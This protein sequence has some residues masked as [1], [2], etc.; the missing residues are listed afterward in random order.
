MVSRGGCEI[1]RLWRSNTHVLATDVRHDGMRDRAASVGAAPRHTPMPN[2]RIIVEPKMFPQMKGTTLVGSMPLSSIFQKTDS[3]SSRRGCR[4]RAQQLNV[5][6]PSRSDRSF[7]RSDVEPPFIHTDVIRTQGPTTHDTSSLVLLVVALQRLAAS[8]RAYLFRTVLD[9]TMSAA[10][11]FIELFGKRTPQKMS[12]RCVSLNEIEPLNFHVCLAY[13]TRA[14]Q[15]SW[16]DSQHCAR[17]SIWRR[18]RPAMK[19]NFWCG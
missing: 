11:A 17:Y 3:T 18:G 10:P 19:R 15:M 4:Q 8:R 9:F 14:L 1:V 16:K 5:R 13:T 7:K 2:C 6:C 12:T